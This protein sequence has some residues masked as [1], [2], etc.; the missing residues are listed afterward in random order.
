MGGIR[1]T[2]SIPTLGTL[3]SRPFDGSKRKGKYLTS[4]LRLLWAVHLT[5]SEISLY[6]ALS[7]PSIQTAAQM[8]LSTLR[9][10]TVRNCCGQNTLNAKHF[11][12]IIFFLIANSRITGLNPDLVL[13][14]VFLRSNGLRILTTLL[15]I[16][17]KPPLE[18]QLYPMQLQ[19]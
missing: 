6:L 17:D 15:N 4:F 5:R 11:I 10:I 19:D 8:T 7:D 13:I 9:P 2:T 16:A 1:I 12:R 3:T 18:L 14:S